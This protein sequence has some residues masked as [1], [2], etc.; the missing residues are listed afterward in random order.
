[1]VRH[2]LLKYDDSVFNRLKKMKGPIS[3]EDFFVS[4]CAIGSPDEVK[5]GD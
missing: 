3:W 5:Q 1:M 2:I 4:R